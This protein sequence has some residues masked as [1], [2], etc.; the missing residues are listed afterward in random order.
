MIL[1]SIVTS[2]IDPSRTVT[3]ARAAFP[4]EEAGFFLGVAGAAGS[5]AGA[6][7]FDSPGI[8]S[9]EHVVRNYSLCWL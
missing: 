2:S 1:T 3:L 9:S 7:A 6:A 8:L 5:A 4:E